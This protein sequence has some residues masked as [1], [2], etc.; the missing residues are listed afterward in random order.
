M[1]RLELFKPLM[2]LKDKLNHFLFNELGLSY[3][4]FYSNKGFY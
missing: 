1:S 4:E 3:G 2:M